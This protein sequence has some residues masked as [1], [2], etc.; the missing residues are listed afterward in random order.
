MTVPTDNVGALT[1][2]FKGSE[3]GE[4][5]RAIS[6]SWEAEGNSQYRVEFTNDLL[7]PNWKL[8]KQISNTLE[9]SQSLSLEETVPDGEEQR[10]FR[11][12]LVK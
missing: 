10:Y 1:V 12:L 2:A 11:V 6:I 5:N 9:S 4:S 8:L 7:E 3:P